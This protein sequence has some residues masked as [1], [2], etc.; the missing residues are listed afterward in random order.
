MC[1]IWETIVVLAYFSVDSAH[2]VLHK[3]MWLMVIRHADHLFE[4]PGI[5]HIYPNIHP[6]R[7]HILWSRT[8]AF[9]EW[10][11]GASCCT[12]C[13]SR[14][15][16]VIFNSFGCNWSNSCTGCLPSSAWAVQKSL[17]QGHHQG[18]VKYFISPPS[19]LVYPLR[20]P[21]PLP[22]LLSMAQTPS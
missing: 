19:P 3:V 21:S 10:M 12:K 8:L 17:A 1:I 20:R 14:L 13:T 7:S 22:R 18:D 4:I 9:I 11:E 15:F 16:S 2:I 5:P 6:L